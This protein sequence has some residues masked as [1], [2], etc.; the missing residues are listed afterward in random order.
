MTFNSAQLRI[1]RP[2]RNLRETR[3]FYEEAVGFS[4]LAEWKD[5]EGYDGA[6]LAIGGPQ[7]QLELLQHATVKPTPT[8]E[9]QIVLYL[10]SI[11]AVADIAQR[12]RG[13]GFVPSVSPNPYWARDEAICFVDPDGYWLIFSPS[14]SAE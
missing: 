3:S 10:G 8:P 2:T 12:I 9:D 11:E 13:Y 6:V 7:R 5:H 1:A 4:V 14:S